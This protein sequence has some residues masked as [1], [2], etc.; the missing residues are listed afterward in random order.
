MITHKNM[1]FIKG[2]VCNSAIFSIGYHGRYSNY[3]KSNTKKLAI[4]NF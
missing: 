4:S 3:E 1:Y 2:L